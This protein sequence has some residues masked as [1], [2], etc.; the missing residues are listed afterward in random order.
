[1]TKSACC[2]GDGDGRE[3]ES[4][5]PPFYDHDH[6]HDHWVRPEG[7]SQCVCDPQLATKNRIHEVVACLKFTSHAVV[8]STTF[9]LTT[10]H[11]N[12]GAHITYATGGTQEAK[13]KQATQR[14]GDQDYHSIQEERRM[15][16]SGLREAD[17][18]IWHA[19]R[20]GEKK[21]TTLIR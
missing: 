15:P 10:D 14:R 7:K 4:A 8:F 18:R 2:H 3:R 20:C 5:Y 9:K 11:D 19:R 16:R 17:Q 1:M 13:I 21:T 6:D 12:R